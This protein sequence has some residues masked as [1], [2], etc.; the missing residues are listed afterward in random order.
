VREFHVLKRRTASDA[1]DLA[2]D[3]E[4]A[5]ELAMADPLTPLAAAKPLQTL[6]SP[7]L[8]EFVFEPALHTS[9]VRVVCTRT[10]AAGVLAGM[11][12]V[13]CVGLFQVCFA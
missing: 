7:Y 5:W 12:G 11:G 3:S 2:D 8:Q 10:A 9:S 4:A 13:D 6:N 1:V